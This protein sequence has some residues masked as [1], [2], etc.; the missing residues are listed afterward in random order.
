[1]YGARRV[2]DTRASR[3]TSGPSRLRSIWRCCPRHDASLLNVNC[4]YAATVGV[5]QENQDN[6]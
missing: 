1:M 5:Q 6:D 3:T 2:G 4:I